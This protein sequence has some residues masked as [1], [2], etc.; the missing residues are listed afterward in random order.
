M[1]EDKYTNRK[2]NT[3]GLLGYQQLE[4]PAANQTA[5]IWFPADGLQ[6]APTAAVDAP[7]SGIFAAVRI[8]AKLVAAPT[9]SVE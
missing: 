2:I 4:L 3:T 9:I 5:S 8:A 1:I 7:F 6:V